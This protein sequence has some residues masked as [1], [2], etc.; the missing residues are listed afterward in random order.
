VIALAFS[1]IGLA[2]VLAFVSL[3]ELRGPM[4]DLA[5][6]SIPLLIVAA[7]IALSMAERMDS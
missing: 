7:A 6:V 2:L 1:F 5:S 4:L 3:M